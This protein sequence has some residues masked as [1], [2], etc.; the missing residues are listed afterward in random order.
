MEAHGAV[1]QRL[2]VEHRRGVV[3]ARR[4]QRDGA[5]EHQHMAVVALL[6]LLLSLLMM[7]GVT[8][9]MARPG[10]LQLKVVGVAVQL[11]K[12]GT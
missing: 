7:V 6:R 11:R 12:T 4:Q 8:L 2:V 1:L 3:V 10:I 5:V 9:K